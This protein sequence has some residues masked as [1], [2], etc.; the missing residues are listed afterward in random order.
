MT[1]TVQEAQAAKQTAADKVNAVAET[2][3]ALLQTEKALTEQIG[4][5][6]AD[7]AAPDTFAAQKAERD[8]VSSQIVDYESA[9]SHLDTDYTV[10]E[11]TLKQAERT[12][13]A[14]AIQAA[15]DQ[16]R[17]DAAAYTDG[18]AA[19]LVARNAMRA[20]ASKLPGVEAAVVQLM[21]DVVSYQLKQTPANFAYASPFAELIEPYLTQAGR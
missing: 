18:F 13:R 9:A 12:A 15:I 7:G 1:S 8:A 2:L 5:A 11:E 21:E 3:R 14:A 19:F 16:A 10:A 20:S 4:R 17:T 6:I